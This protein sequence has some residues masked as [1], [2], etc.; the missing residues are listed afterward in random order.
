MAQR[1]ILEDESAAWERWRVKMIEETR[2]PSDSCEFHELDAL[3]ERYRA[4]GWRVITIN[5]EP[6]FLYRRVFPRRVISRLRFWEREYECGVIEVTPRGDDYMISPIDAAAVL[7]TRRRWRTKSGDLIIP[8]MLGTCYGFS[9]TPA[10]YDISKS[11]AEHIL[12]GDAVTAFAD[13]VLIHGSPWCMIP[14]IGRVSLDD[15][16]DRWATE[17]QAVTPQNGETIAYL[18]WLTDGSFNSTHLRGWMWKERHK[19]YEQ[20]VGPVLRW[21]CRA[22]AGGATI[23][24]AV[25]SILAA[26]GHFS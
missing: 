20:I 25:L 2:G 13:R 1:Q 6:L 24:T 22:I 17:E 16:A 18:L 8:E 3:L 9:S 10:S 4:K 23:V 21:T 7:P 11:E 26:L 5:G 14:F 19:W 12:A 15:L